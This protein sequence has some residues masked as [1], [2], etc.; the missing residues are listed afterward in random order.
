MILAIG[1][2]GFL[3]ERFAARWKTAAAAVRAVRDGVLAG[4]RSVAPEERPRPARTAGT[5]EPGA[6]HRAAG[7]T[8]ADDQGQ[9]PARLRRGGRRGRGAPFVA[10]A[11]TDAGGTRDLLARTGAAAGELPG[12]SASWASRRR[13]CA[14]PS[15]PRCWPPA[16]ITP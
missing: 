11:L 9:R 6:R 10:L 12:A 3:A 1:Q 2:D 16:P 4:L 13:N 15:W 8:G 7:G 14:T 5:A